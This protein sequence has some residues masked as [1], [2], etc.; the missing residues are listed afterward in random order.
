MTVITAKEMAEMRSIADDYFPDTCTIQTETEAVDALGGITSS[1]ANTHLRVPCRLDPFS[2]SVAGT[3]AP[4]NSALEGQTMWTLNIPYDQAISIE[5]RVVHDSVTY[6]VAA[7]WDTQSY[8]T[9]RRAQLIR[10]N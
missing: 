4:T 2:G 6:E 9:I 7:V 8:R 10:V 1:W 5:M 3:E